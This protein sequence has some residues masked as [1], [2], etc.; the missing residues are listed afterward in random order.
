[1]HDLGLY[2]HFD[3]R[4]ADITAVRTT[5][6]LH[7]LAT[8]HLALP[9]LRQLDRLLHRK[10]RITVDQRTDQGALVEW[11]ADRQRRINLLQTRHDRVINAVVHEQ[12]SQGSTALAGRADCGERNGAHCHF[13]IGARCNDH[14]IVAAQFQN[15]TCQARCATFCDMTAHTRAAGCADQ[16]HALVIDQYG[17]AVVIANHQLRQIFRRI[18][19]EACNR[20][21]EQ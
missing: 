1:M 14:G 4:R 12:A 18:V 9:G 5:F 6:D 16:W 20:A 15:R 10:V 17:A 7:S 11:I 2:W 19:T 13:D 3:Q 21:H 8:M